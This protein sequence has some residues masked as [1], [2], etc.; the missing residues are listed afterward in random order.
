MTAPNDI[1]GP[2]TEACREGV[3]DAWFGYGSGPG[4]SGSAPSMDDIDILLPGLLGAGGGGRESVCV[5]AVG[6]AAAGGGAC[7]NRGGKC[8]GD[9]GGMGGR[10]GPYMIGGAG[11]SE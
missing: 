3:R 4:F 7:E 1:D 6:S 9:G 5:T 11:G 8:C 10:G 2:D